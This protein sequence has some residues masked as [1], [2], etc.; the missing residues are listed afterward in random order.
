[1]VTVVVEVVTEEGVDLAVAEGVDAA[2]LVAAE[3]VVTE[4]AL[5]ALVVTDTWV[6]SADTTGHG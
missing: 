4:E 3:E 5:V 6:D 1:L 2:Y